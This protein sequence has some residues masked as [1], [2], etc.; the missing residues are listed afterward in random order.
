MS[1][2]LFEFNYFSVVQR[3][4]PVYAIRDLQKIVNYGER[5]RNKDAMAVVCDKDQ[6]EKG[7][8]FVLHFRGVGNKIL[9]NSANKSN[10]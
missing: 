3:G 8:V 6:V 5:E 2:G 9:E 1:L 7:N 10:I 4:L